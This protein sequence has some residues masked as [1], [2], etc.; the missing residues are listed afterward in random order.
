MSYNWTDVLRSLHPCHALVMLAQLAT[1]CYM[2]SVCTCVYSM[3][4]YPCVYFLGGSMFH[5]Y[6]SMS[7]IGLAGQQ[8]DLISL[9][10]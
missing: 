9:S 10:R 8:N 1:C 2:Y 5:K 6:G 4:D 7:M 3:Y